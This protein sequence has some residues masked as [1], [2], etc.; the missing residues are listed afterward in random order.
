MKYFDANAMIGEHFS[1]R[2]EKFFQAGDLIKEMDFFGIDDALV[3]HG[4]ARE[5][6]S[7]FGNRKLLDCLQNEPRLHACWVVGAPSFNPST[8]PRQLM[9]EALKAN[10]K[11]VRFFWGG[12]LTN[13]TVLDFDVLGNLFE[14]VE[15][16]RMPMIMENDS[17]T[18]IAGGQL[19]DLKNVCKAFPKLPVILVSPKLSR[20][21]ALIYSMLDKFNN[22][23]LEISG[24]HGSGRMEEIGRRFGA[25][26]LIYGTHFPWFGGGQT[27]IS[28]AY[29]DLPGKDKEAIASGNL[30]RLIKGIRK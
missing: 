11:A 19:V 2:E 14:A 23:H 7:E 16:H 20:D 26:H 8:S 24:M 25:S 28:L 10:V 27:R 13:F 21:F 30:T 18:E 22:F 29:A 15:A 6:E 4:M 12:P 1:P 17:G 9:K 5:Y 3:Y